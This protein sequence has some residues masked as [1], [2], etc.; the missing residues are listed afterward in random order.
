MLD[1]LKK[2]IIVASLEN[3][4]V[5]CTE[6]ILS[7]SAKTTVP[8]VF[9]NLKHYAA[10]LIMHKLDKLDFKMYFIPSRLEK[11]MSF[12]FDNKLLFIDSFQSSSLD[13]LVKKVRGK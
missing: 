9:H 10:H 1:L 7:M 6:I 12:S 4:G 13:S 2:E 8:T 5:L 11:Y 3:L